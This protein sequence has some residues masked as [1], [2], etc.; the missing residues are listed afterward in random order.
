MIT[1]NGA[2]AVEYLLEKANK[3]KRRITYLGGEVE[4]LTTFGEFYSDG[5]SR[6][7]DMRAYAEEIKI[8]LESLIREL[9]KGI[10]K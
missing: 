7:K 10:G 5:S 3:V 9:D 2:L 4:S 8:E 1:T 6:L